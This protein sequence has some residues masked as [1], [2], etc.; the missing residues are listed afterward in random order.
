MHIPVLFQRRKLN[1]FSF[2]E[3]GWYCYVA[4][5]LSPLHTAPPSNSH[6]WQLPHDVWH[7]SYGPTWP[8]SNCLASRALANALASPC[9]GTPR[10]GGGPPRGLE[11]P[12]RNPLLRRSLTRRSM[13]GCTLKASCVMLGL[14]MRADQRRTECSDT[15]KAV[16]TSA[17]MPS[18]QPAVTWSPSVAGLAALW[19]RDWMHTVLPVW[20]QGMLRRRA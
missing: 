13:Y 6:T 8:L 10:G 20:G 4:S 7:A 19:P 2:S 15:E 1:K 14:H 12:T 3:N 11:Q 5:T 16:V 9:A 18:G 17:S